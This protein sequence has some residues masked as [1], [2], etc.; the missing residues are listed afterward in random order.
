MPDLWVRTLDGPASG[1]D[2]RH[3]ASGDD[4]DD[5]AFGLFRVRPFK[6]GD[7]KRLQYITQN[8]IMSHGRPWPSHK[9]PL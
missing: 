4:L 3:D 6:E 7:G 1:D 9:T 5:L 2:F 8:G